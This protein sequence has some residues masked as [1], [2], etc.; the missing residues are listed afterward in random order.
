MK[1][2]AEKILLILLLTSLAIPCL[3]F[4]TPLSDNYIHYIAAKHIIE[5]PSILTRTDLTGL[6]SMFFGSSIYY[7]PPLLHLSYA[8]LFLMGIVPKFL[9]IISIAVVCIFLYKIDKRALPLMALSFMFIRVSVQGGIDIF[10]LALAVLSFYYYEKKPWLG[11]IFA[12]LVALVKTSGLFFLGGYI[13]TI[14]LFKG[15][16][17]FKERKKVYLVA[18]VI[19]LLVPSPWY[20]MNFV[21]NNG[22]F[23]GTFVGTKMS[24]IA[25]YEEWLQTPF[26]QNQPERKMF[27][28][29]GYY[30]LPIDLL[31]YIGLVFVAINLVRTRKFGMEHVFIFLF[32]AVYFVAQGIQFN[33]L[34]TIRYYLPIFPLL[35]I[36][37]AKSIPEKYLKFVYIACIALLLFWLSVLPNYAWNQTDAQMDGVCATIR[38]NV[39]KEP[40]HVKAFQSWYTIYRCDLNATTE[41]LSKWTVDLDQGSIYLTNHT[42]G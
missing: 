14:L 37:I 15:K 2:E 26:Q 16:E 13:I 27:D 1:I 36:Q 6:P 11:A 9:D 21:K 38:N 40:V 20:A 25:G 23:I 39:L 33:Y 17:I 19:A 34:M 31:F 3:M 42:V 24:E 41:E 7:Y 22:D 35:A 29:S 30:P 5:D 28:T 10:M 32:T 4:V 8:L 12:G 18:L